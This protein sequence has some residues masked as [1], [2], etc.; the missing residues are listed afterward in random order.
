VKV[1]GSLGSTQRTQA[2]TYLAYFFADNPI[3]MW[4]R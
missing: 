4:G 3:L 2:Q 1:L